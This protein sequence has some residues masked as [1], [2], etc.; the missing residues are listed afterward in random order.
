MHVSGQERHEARLDC[1]ST[2]LRAMPVMRTICANMLS[3]AWFRLRRCCKCS[4][5]YWQCTCIDLRLP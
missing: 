2:E 5:C 4:T 1:R 3:T